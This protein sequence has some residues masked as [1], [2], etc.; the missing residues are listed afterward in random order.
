L[1]RFFRRSAAPQVVQ[2]PPVAV[3]LDELFDVHKH[4]PNI[5]VSLRVDFVPFKVLGSKWTPR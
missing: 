4:V 5:F 2:L 1:L 3:L